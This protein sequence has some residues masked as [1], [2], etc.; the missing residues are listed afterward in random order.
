MTIPMSKEY[1][2]YADSLEKQLEDIYAVVTKARKKGLD[3]ALVPE[4]EVA[5]DLAALVEGLVGPPGVAES[6]RDLTKTLSR[7]A[8]TF[9]ITEQII[10][11]KF[12]VMDSREAG[13]QAM[14]TALAILTE[15]IT[16]APIQGIAKVDIKTNSDRTRYLAI[17]YAGPIRSAGGTEQALT[18]IVGDHI[19]R[20]LKLDRYKPTEDEIGRFIEEI[21]LFERSIARFQ[22]HISDEELRRGLQNIPVEVTG[23]ESDPVEVSTFRNLP[24][25]ETNNVRGGALRVVNDGIVGRA[26]K[27]L[28]TIEKLQ[29]PGWEWLGNLKEFSKKKK[30]GFMADVI[31]GRPIFSFPSRFGGFRLRYGRSR[32]TGLAAVGIHPATMLTVQNFLAAGTQLRLEGPGKGGITVPVDSIEPPVV[33]LKNGSVVRVTLQNFDSINKMIDKILFLGDILIGFGDFLYTNK[34][35]R[36]AGYNEEWWGEEL[37][38]A[39]DE[40]FSGD[41]DKTAKALGLEKSFLEKILIDVYQNTPPL[42]DALQLSSIL[43]VPL[44]PFYTYFW[45]TLSAEEFVALRNWL[46]ASEIKVENNT[47]QEIVGVKDKSIKFILEKLCIQ[48]ELIL[49]TV[50][51]GG[52]E[53]HIFAFCLGF[54]KPDCTIESSET[55]QDIIRNLTGLIV[56]PKGVSFV[57]ARMGRPEKAKHRE[58]KPLVHTLFPVGLAGGSRRNLIDASKKVAIEVDLV[59]RRCVK[60]NAPSFTLKCVQCGSDTV[61]EKTC[62]QCGRTLDLN[63]CPAC[64]TSTRS[65][66]RQEVDIRGLL[67][68]ACKNLGLPMLSLFKGVKGMTNETKTPEILEKGL[69]RAKHGLSVFKD[70][71]IRFDATNA[72]LSHFTPKEVGV[73]VEQIK[74]NGYSHDYK[75]NPLTTPEQICELKVQDIVIPRKCATYFLKVA[76]FLDELLEKVYK[77]QKYYNLTKSSDLVG[78]LVIGLAPHTSVGI[79]GRIIGFTPLN[80]IY[81]HHMWH[82][83]KRRD[84]DGDEDAVILGMDAILN[85]S[86]EFLPSQIGGIMDAPILIIPVVNPLEVQRQAHEVDVTGKYP[87]EFYQKALEEADTRQTMGIIDVIADRLNTP[88]QFEGFKYTIPVSNINMGN[89][90]SVYKKFGKMIDK[91]HSQLVLAEKIAAV[92]ADVVA[93]KVLTTHFIRDIAGN[94]RAFTTQQFRCKGCNRKFRRMPLIGKCPSCNSDLILTVYRGG[95]EKYLIAATRLVE[96]YGLLDYYAQRLNMVEEEILTLFEGKKPRQC[97]LEAFS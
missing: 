67:S 93:R 70:G 97:S 89:T 84:C 79:V 9:K 85:F 74:A 31:A 49:N 18:I 20:L 59:K 32:N 82:S 56:K 47:V 42:P 46:L 81:A 95:I 15:G 43:G 48:H 28:T 61:L 62:P 53:A 91:M 96:K 40:K 72:P 63:E 5:K 87:L 68:M 77:L 2:Q 55:V 36:P 30:S 88:A 64:K 33:R 52:D 10:N 26:A 23:T 22:Y 94:L 76:N 37:T 60:C 19:R 3:P 92:D 24:R 7:E 4:P 66:A 34:P 27:V 86:K 41:L 65:Y 80:V 29:I 45:E 38:V 16:A 12:G 50:K 21:R 73:T 78:C 13:E 35:L 51:I 1:K 69:L 71:T 14:R 75:G 58:M 25:I 39:V 44:H 90:E 8:L 54:N 6:I 17:Y 11:G 57:G 83:A